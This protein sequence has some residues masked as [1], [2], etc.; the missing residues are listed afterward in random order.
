MTKCSGSL[1]RW[2]IEK[3]QEENYKRQKE[4]NESQAGNQLRIHFLRQE[5][6][7]ANNSKSPAPNLQG[8]SREWRWKGTL[9]HHTA[10][11]GGAM[12]HGTKPKMKAKTLCLRE[13]LQTHAFR[14]VHTHLLCYV[15][16]CKNKHPPTNTKTNT[17]MHIDA[18][19]SAQSQVSHAAIVY[20]STLAIF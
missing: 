6:A 5:E 12:V 3:R 13:T 2:S 9:Q 19:T 14:R 15:H 16:T 1:Q 20:I 11:S 7:A 17:D 8:W 18:A 4:N 10:G